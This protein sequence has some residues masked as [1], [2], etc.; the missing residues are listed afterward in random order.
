MWPF[1]KKRKPEVRMPPVRRPEPYQTSTLDSDPLNP[2]GDGT[3]CPGDP[4]FDAAMRGEAVY[5][6]RNADDSWDLTHYPDP[7]DER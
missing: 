1:K 2:H 7:L 5:G 4:I 3:L 6:V